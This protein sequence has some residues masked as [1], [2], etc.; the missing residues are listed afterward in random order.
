VDNIVAELNQKYHLVDGKKLCKSTLYRT[1][2]HGKA[3]ESPMKRGPAPKIPE[4]LIDVATL[5]TEVNQ[6]GKGRQLRGR[7][8]K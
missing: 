5:H 3:G 8:I 6:V 4:V 2:C 1:V 7:D